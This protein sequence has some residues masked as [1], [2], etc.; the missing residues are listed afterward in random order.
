MKEYWKRQSSSKTAWFGSCGCSDC[1]DSEC[2]DFSLDCN[3]LDSDTEE[4][5]DYDVIPQLYKMVC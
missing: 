2:E 3:P 5:D 1:S 4:N